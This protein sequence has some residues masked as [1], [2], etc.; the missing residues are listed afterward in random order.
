MQLSIEIN[1]E[2]NQIPYCIVYTMLYFQGFNIFHVITCKEVISVPTIV[3][4][5]GSIAVCILGLT[6]CCDSHRLV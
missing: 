5:I 4:L 1:S 6:V 2:N 3:L